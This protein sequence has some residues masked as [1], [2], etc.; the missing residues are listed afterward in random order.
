[1][2]QAPFP[3][4]CE[5]DTVVI[6]DHDGA[7][8]DRWDPRA[9]RPRRA[10]L[11]GDPLR[12]PVG[13]GSSYRMGIV[14]RPI[15]RDALTFGEAEDLR[16]REV[17]DP[18]KAVSLGREKDV[19]RSEDVGGDDVSGSAGAVV[20]DRSGMDDG[21]AP[22]RCFEHLGFVPQ[23]AAGRHVERSD[24]VTLGL[25]TGQ[26][27]PPHLSRRA[28]DQDSA[29]PSI[30]TDAACPLDGGRRPARSDQGQAAW[31]GAREITTSRRR[32]S[33][34]AAAMWVGSEAGGPRAARRVGVRWSRWSPASTGRFAR[35]R[36]L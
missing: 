24:A 3:R 36:R 26:D 33:E 5:L 21:V 16:R 6:E 22:H 9:R 8:H 11:F 10:H 14:H 23:I 35:G 25:K 31:P 18:R 32:E 34:R 19:P 28:G 20:R 17:D 7:K 15:L 4:Q 29:H 12:H 13:T 27:R 2:R 30:F 1:M